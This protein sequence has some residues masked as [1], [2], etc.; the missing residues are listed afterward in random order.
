MILQ[1]YRVNTAVTHYA[2]LERLL[3]NFR[4]GY[5]HLHR[6]PLQ[7]VRRPAVQGCPERCIVCSPL[8]PRNLKQLFRSSRGPD[9]F[10]LD[11]GNGKC[12]SPQGT[13]DA[14]DTSFASQTSLKLSAMPAD[15][16]SRYSLLCCRPCLGR[17]QT[18]KLANL[19]KI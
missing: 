17:A 15:R 9:H 6:G 19:L 7:S 11:Q 13:H 12:K 3:R 2:E 5:L 1:I 8:G 16:P 4:S 18:L 10:R 14:M